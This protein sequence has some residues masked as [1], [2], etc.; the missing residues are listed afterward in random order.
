MTSQHI[1]A[2]DVHAHYGNYHRDDAPPPVNEFV[3]GDVA[4]VVA[5]ARQ[6]NVRTTIASPL[7]GVLPRGRADAVAGNIEGSGSLLRPMGCCSTSSR[8][9]C[10]RDVSS[11]GRDAR[12]TAMR[13]HQDSPRRARLSN[14]Q[15]G[16]VPSNSQPDTMRSCW[17]TAVTRTVCRAISWTL[18]IPTRT[19]G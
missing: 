9:P 12:V 13:R 14:P 2:I 18:P 7:S 11:G 3:S 5:R 1:Q 15:H 10:R 19:C 4:T 6:V 16:E 17:P 8:I